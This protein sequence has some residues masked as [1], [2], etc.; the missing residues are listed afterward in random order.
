MINSKPSS[1]AC[2]T[3]YVTYTRTY[4]QYGKIVINN[5]HGDLIKEGT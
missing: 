2:E 4:K 3:G 1:Y 5:E